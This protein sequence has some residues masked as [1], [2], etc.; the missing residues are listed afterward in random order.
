MRHCRHADHIAL[1][2]LRLQGVESYEPQVVDMLID[3]VYSYSKDV[4]GDAAAYGEAAGR[5]TGHVH[6]QD[7]E[8]AIRARNF[9]QPLSLQ[10]RT[11]TCAT[12]VMCARTFPGLAHCAPRAHASTDRSLFERGCGELQALKSMVEDLNRQALPDVQGRPGLPLPA[13]GTLLVPNVQYGDDAGVSDE[14]E[15]GDGDSPS[16]MAV[17]A[18]PAPAALPGA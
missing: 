14:D 16:T 5:A 15:H 17:D 9:A 11:A 6:A 1:R 4:L 3:F 10:V 2:A 18:A 7:V 12:L 13:E 8:L